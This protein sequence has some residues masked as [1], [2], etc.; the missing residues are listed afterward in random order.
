MG[1][2]GLV[3]FNQDGLNIGINSIAVQV[4]RCV[5]VWEMLWRTLFMQWTSHSQVIEEKP[6]C[7]IVG[8]G[9]VATASF[10]YPMPTWDE[11]VYTWRLLGGRQKKVACWV[12]IGCSAVLALILVTLVYHHKGNF[13]THSCIVQLSHTMW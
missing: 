10:I 5:V 12:S 11:R 9:T 13:Y 7:E 2:F 1:T 8:P 3:R 4:S 6:S